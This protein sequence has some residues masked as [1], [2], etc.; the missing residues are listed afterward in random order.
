MS[1]MVR[2]LGPEALGTLTSPTSAGADLGGWPGGAPAAPPGGV[3]A[4][5]SANI[6]APG[7]RG[8]GVAVPSKVP[9]AMRGQVRSSVVLLKF[10]IHIAP[11]TA[12][13][14]PTATGDFGTAAQTSPSGDEEAMRR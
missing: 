5:P 2:P 10:S 13:V 3:L 4:A 6:P 8:E 7:D 11:T 14:A 1:E 9:K 12:T